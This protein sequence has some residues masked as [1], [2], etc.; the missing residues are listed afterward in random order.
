ME[1]L[2]VL[3]LYILYLADPPSHR[4]SGEMSQCKTGIR[5]T[6]GTAC[7]GLD[8]GA[9]PGLAMPEE[10]ICTSTEAV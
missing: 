9:V 2:L 7:C 10:N 8:C 3:P 1:T 4:V 6:A 5:V